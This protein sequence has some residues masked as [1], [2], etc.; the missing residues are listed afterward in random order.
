ELG[1]NAVKLRY[2]FINYFAQDEF[3]VSPRL[4]L[5]FGIRYEAMLNPVLDDQAPFELSRQVNNDLNKFAPRFGFSWSPLR[6][7]K[8]VVRGGYGMFYD[9]PSLSASSTAA[10]VNG[11]RLLS[12]TVPGTDPRAPRYPDLLTSGIAA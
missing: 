7:N 11:R 10:L 4:T 9:T 12:Y 1:E 5:N 3:R 8:L 2:H 6:D